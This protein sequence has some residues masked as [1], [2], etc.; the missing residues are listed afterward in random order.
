MIID[1]EFIAD[2]FLKAAAAVTPEEYKK[3]P[4]A[5]ERRFAQYISDYTLGAAIKEVD[6]CAEACGQVYG[7]GSAIPRAI[8]L[9][10]QQLRDMK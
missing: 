5:R 9:C 2:A 8:L 4:W 3:E 10:A 7:E 1:H 6:A